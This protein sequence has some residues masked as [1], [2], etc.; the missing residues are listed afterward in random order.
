MFS[1]GTMTMAELTSISDFT[2]A[3]SLMK[4]H[5]ALLMLTIIRSQ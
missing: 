2:S 3:L 1:K 4:V 5:R